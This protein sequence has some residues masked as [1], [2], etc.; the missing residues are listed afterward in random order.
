MALTGTHDND[1][2]I[3]RFYGSNDHFTRTSDEIRRERE[4]TLRY[5]GCKDKRRKD[6]QWEFIRLLMMSVANRVI[7]FMQ[8]L[9]GLGEEASMNRPANARGNWEWRLT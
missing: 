4:N 5:P 3:G 6:F 7:I 1:T 2:L 8:E 9:L